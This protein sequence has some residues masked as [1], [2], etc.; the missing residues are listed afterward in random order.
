[1]FVGAINSSL[2]WWFSLF[3]VLFTV[4]LAIEKI[5]SKKS[6]R[7]VRLLTMFAALASVGAFIFSTISSSKLTATVQSMQQPVAFTAHATLKVKSADRFDPASSSGVYQA[8]LHV[9][10][11]KR[12]NERPG[13]HLF[14]LN[15]ENVKPWRAEGE[16]ETYDPIFQDGGKTKLANGLTVDELLQESDAAV[17]TALFLLPNNVYEVLGGQT[18]HFSIRPQKVE[19]WFGIYATA[20]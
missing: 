9:G 2:G 11:S 3:T 6:S 1:M 20:D 8:V 14:F 13:G 15:C 4:S 16:E 5:S 18:K 7:W 19:G 17:V 12:L 10:N